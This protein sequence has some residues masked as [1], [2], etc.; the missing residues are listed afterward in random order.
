MEIY[1]AGKNLEKIEKNLFWNFTGIYF[2]I[3]TNLF[4]NINANF[5]L[6]L[7]SEVFSK[8]VSRTVQVFFSL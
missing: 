8:Q 3:S 1:R 6:Y 4:G 5:D 2:S 7:V